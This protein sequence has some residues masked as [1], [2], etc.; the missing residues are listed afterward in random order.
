MS[1]D[2]IHQE[3]T[4]TIIALLEKGTPPWRRTWKTT[5]GNGSSSSVPRNAITRRPYQGVN[6]IILWAAAL[7]GSYPS[8]DWATYRQIQAAGGQVRKGERGTRVVLYRPVEASDRKQPGE[9]LEE[10]HNNKGER[11]MWI[12]RAFTVFNVAQCDGLAQAPVPAAPPR[13]AIPG[14]EQFVRH[15]GARVLHGGDG[16]FYD[17]RSD[18]IHLPSSD[19]FTSAEAY[20][21]TALH[22]HVHWT[23]HAERLNRFDKW[24]PFGSEAYACEELVAELGAAFLCADLDV[25][26]ELEHHASY[27]G[28]WLTV[29]KRDAK[30]LF[31]AAAD[32]N[33]AAEYLRGLQPTRVEQAA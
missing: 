14:A 2:S 19:S 25:R 1:R 22:E 12:M 3:V 29:L 17:P 10:D 20:Y 21:A 31:G 33:R 11:T 9:T 24:A 5:A 16:A 6:R 30:A 7:A 13:D 27:L 8:H 23:G 4:N 18:T 28:H 15:V 32:A 26:G